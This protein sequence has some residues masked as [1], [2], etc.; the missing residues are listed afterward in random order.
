MPFFR[1]LMIITAIVILTP[2]LAQAHDSRPVSLRITETS[3]DLFVVRWQVP[4]S[5]K[6]DNRPTPVLPEFCT[7]FGQS[8]TEATPGAIVSEQLF[9]CGAALSNARIRL[10]YPT[11]SPSLS[12][13]M[14]IEWLT[15]EV[16]DAVLGPQDDGWVVPEKE[17][18]SSV[19]KRYFGFGM[20][21][22]FK[23]YDHLLF[24][25][26]LM[27]I[28]RTPR[29][30]IFTVTGF[31][32]AHS[33]TLALAALGLV[34]LPVMVVEAV[35]ALSIVFVAVEIA[36]ER[37]DTLAFQFPVL[38]SVAFGLL[39]G[40]AFASVL[41]DIGLPQTKLPTALL[42]FNLGIE[43]GQLIIITP[44]F[45]LFLLPDGRLQRLTD[46]LSW[47][48]VGWQTLVAYPVGALASFWFLQRI[49]QAVV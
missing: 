4:S 14:R 24:L 38:V 41:A 31:T 8:R 42:L 13:V 25:M 29:R 3:D 6:A 15:G 49:M 39:H 28:A 32:L 1:L 44:I 16:Q 47:G 17:S 23:G 48:P 30:I 2:S 33:V 19:S 10:K 37:R 22:I 9:R 27:I 12:T 5:L 35:I 43:V 46:K 36:R 34:R 45:L 18:V 20:Q 26:C 21:H 40:L 11:F 7:A